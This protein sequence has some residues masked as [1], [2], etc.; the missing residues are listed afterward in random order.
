MGRP[1]LTLALVRDRVAKR[2]L[3]VRSAQE[4]LQ[5]A[6]Q[7][8]SLRKCLGAWDLTF[9]GLVRAAAAEGC[10]QGTAAVN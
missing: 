6:E 5:R 4:H 8:D 2:A 9:L 7:G 1:R 10:T 3:S